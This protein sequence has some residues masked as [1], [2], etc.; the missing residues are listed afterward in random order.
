MTMT[1]AAAVMPNVLFF[2]QAIWLTDAPPI[3]VR[4]NSG[5][6]IEE[7]IPCAFMRADNLFLALRW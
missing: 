1:T 7:T 5:N 3:H 6:R 4:A 2:I